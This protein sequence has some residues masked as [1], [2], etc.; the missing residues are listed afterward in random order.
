MHNRTIKELIDL[1]DTCTRR[2]T[3]TFI[4]PSATLQL[5]GT[6][7]HEREERRLRGRRRMEAVGTRDGERPRRRRR[8]E[9]ARTMTDDSRAYDD[10]RR[11]RGRRRQEDGAA[12]TT[13]ARGTDRRRDELD[14]FSDVRDSISSAGKFRRSAGEGAAR[15][16]SHD[17]KSQSARK[18]ARGAPLDSNSSKFGKSFSKPLENQICSFCQINKDSKCK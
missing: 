6:Y 7:L 11:P 8:M 9:A 16:S 12:M 4:N 17:G 18:F 1:A 10:R 15:A 3:Y 2:L 13:T 5:P 14:L